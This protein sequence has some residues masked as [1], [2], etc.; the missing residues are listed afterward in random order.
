M[1]NITQEARSVHLINKIPSFTC[2]FHQKNYVFH[3]MVR[4][5]VKISD[6]H[7]K[8]WGTII[9]GMMDYW[10]NHFA[11]WQKRSEQVTTNMTGKY[12]NILHHNKTQKQL[13]YFL[14]ILQKYYQL[15]L[16]WVLYIC[17]A[18]FIEICLYASKKWTPS[19]TS[20]LRYFKGI[21]NLL[22]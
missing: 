11:Y 17:L 13:A 8:V 19:L 1:I 2:E 18:S 22:L 6:G 20:F 16:F 4:E 12:L 9:K 5:K 21:A 7:Q 3:D 15:F 10:E 14:N